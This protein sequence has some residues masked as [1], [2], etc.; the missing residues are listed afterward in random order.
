MRLHLEN[1]VVKIPT[2]I[3]NNPVYLTVVAP[4]T[5]EK[6][7]IEAIP[8]N[9]ENYRVILENCLVPE[10]REILFKH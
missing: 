2:I 10:T 5:F 4:Y 3:S 8:V 1:E 6:D 9:A 7:H